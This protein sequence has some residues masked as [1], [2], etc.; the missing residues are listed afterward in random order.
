MYSL[1]LSRASIAAVLI[2]F[3]SLTSALLIFHPDHLKSCLLR[4]KTWTSHSRSHPSR[5]PATTFLKRSV[6]DMCLFSYKTSLFMVHHVLQKVSKRS[7]PSEFAP[8][9]GGLVFRCLKM[10]LCSSLPNCIGIHGFSSSLTPQ[11]MFYIFHIYGLVTSFLVFSTL[12][13]DVTGSCK[14]NSV[15]QTC[16]P[17]ITTR[18]YLNSC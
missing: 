16:C 18:G 14:H 15:K 4:L 1:A 3:L 10:F 6:P 17:S 9:L 8:L 7:I 2:L 5:I 13:S 12:P 11:K